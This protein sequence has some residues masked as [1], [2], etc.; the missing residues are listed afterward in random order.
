MSIQKSLDKIN[1]K[2]FQVDE[3][4]SIVR[5]ACGLRLPSA[6]DLA[7]LE[8]LEALRPPSNNMGVPYPFTPYYFSHR[9]KYST[10]DSRLTIKKGPIS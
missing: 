2:E 6:V 4:Q 10:F 8:G 1:L 7:V 9:G 5:D 3:F